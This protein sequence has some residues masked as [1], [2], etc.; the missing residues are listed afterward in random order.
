MD[1]RRKF[2]DE[3]GRVLGR[4]F[5]TFLGSFGVA[6]FGGFLGRKK[7]YLRSPSKKKAQFV[8][9]KSAVC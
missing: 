5:R 3:I 6:K 2:R 4:C 9:T 7:K 8:V 1:F